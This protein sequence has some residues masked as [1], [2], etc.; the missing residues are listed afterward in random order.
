MHINTGT[1]LRANPGI[2][3]LL[4]ESSLSL[5]GSIL[6]SEGISS[7]SDRAKHLFVDA[8]SS[9]ENSSGKYP[10]SIKV[11]SGYGTLVTGNIQF[12]TSSKSSKYSGNSRI[13]TGVSSV[14]K[15]GN[16]ELLSG[17]S[18]KFGKNDMRVLVGQSGKSG[19]I[20]LVAGTSSSFISGKINI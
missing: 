2:L 3:A 20:L 14:A 12:R 15:S 6:V 10:G 7:Q 16:I 9:H 13:K 19:A 1:S 18:Y 5:P 8:G 4:S 11:R 17:S